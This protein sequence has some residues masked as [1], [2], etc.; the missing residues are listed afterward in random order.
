MRP[1]Y[2]VNYHSVSVTDNGQII[3]N[4]I[5]RLIALLS[6]VASAVLIYIYIDIAAEFNLFCIFRSSELKRITVFQP[7]IGHLHLIAVTNLLFKHT[8]TIADT[9][10]VCG[11]PQ[12]CK[13]IQKTTIFRPPLPVLHPV[14]DPLS[15]SNLSNS[16]MLL[17]RLICADCNINQTPHQKFHENNKRTSI[18]LSH[19]LPALSSSYKICILDCIGYA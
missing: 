6:E 19:P 17:L 8:V 3:G 13:R 10:A 9:T 1:R 12:S 14:P 15:H 5:H 11:I 2:E 7:I 16:S 18:L 4:G